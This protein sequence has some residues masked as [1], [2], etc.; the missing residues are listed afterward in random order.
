MAG[1]KGRSAF[2]EL[3]REEVQV[4]RKST[5]AKNRPTQES[6]GQNG[7]II[8][9]TQFPRALLSLFRFAAYR[10]ALPVREYILYRDAF[11]RESTYYY[12][13]RCDGTLERDY[14]AYCDRCGQCL[15]WEHIAKAK[16]RP[17]EGRSS[18]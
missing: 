15:N 9:K 6:F 12:C 1:S 14:Q 11:G 3:V 7:P 17:F 2:S 13:P 10:I 16:R 5:G 8:G 18:K 4:T